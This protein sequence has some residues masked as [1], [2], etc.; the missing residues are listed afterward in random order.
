MAFTGLEVQLQSFF[1]IVERPDI[2]TPLND[3]L[4]QLD[5]RLGGS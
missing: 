5:R 4:F 3:P 1:I 2:L